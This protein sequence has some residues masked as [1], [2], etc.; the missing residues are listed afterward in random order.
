MPV[1]VDFKVLYVAKPN[2][3]N[4]NTNNTFFL[5]ERATFLLLATPLQLNV[6]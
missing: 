6:L 4:K 3:D 5:F 2:S 1:E